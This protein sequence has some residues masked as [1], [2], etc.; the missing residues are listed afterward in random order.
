MISSLRGSVSSLRGT[1]QSP[2][3]ERGVPVIARRNDSLPRTS[4]GKAISLQRTSLRVTKQSHNKE[5]ETY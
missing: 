5:E 3:P 1:K 2:K 4:F